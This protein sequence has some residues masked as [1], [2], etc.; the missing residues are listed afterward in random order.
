MTRRD[1]HRGR[2]FLHQ[3][4]AYADAAAALALGGVAPSLHAPYFMLVAHSAELALKAVIAGG[5]ADDD[6]LI[7]LGHDLPLCL[8]CANAEGLG[9]DPAEGPIAGVLGE[10]AMPHLAQTLRYPAYLAWPLP[11]PAAALDALTVLLAQVGN[12]LTPSS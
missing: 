1:L 4:Q 9:V 8:R 11:E 3:A 10:L 2:R 5:D 7:R 6:D 12:V